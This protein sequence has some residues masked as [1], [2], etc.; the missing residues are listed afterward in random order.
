MKMDILFIFFLENKERKENLQ[1][2][3]LFKFQQRMVHNQMKEKDP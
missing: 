3:F 1:P 2:I